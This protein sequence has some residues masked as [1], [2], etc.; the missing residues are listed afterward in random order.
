MHA[1]PPAAL[2]SWSA[3]VALLRSGE[4]VG[5]KDGSYGSCCDRLPALQLCLELL[6]LLHAS[7]QYYVFFELIVAM[8]SI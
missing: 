6:Y 7:E 3:S 1:T 8:D 2:H 5:C 4:Y